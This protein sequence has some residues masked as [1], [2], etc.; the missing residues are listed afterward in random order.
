GGAPKNGVSLFIAMLLPFLGMLLLLVCIKPFA[1]SRLQNLVWGNTG[2]PQLRFISE[3]RFRP[4]LWLT[5]KN[6]LLIVL[7]LG[8]YWPFALVAMT[9]LR[10]EAVSIKT[11]IDPE[12]LV[13][14]A[15]TAQIEA[16]GD[17][18]GDFF[19]LDVGL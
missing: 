15:Q 6:W 13:A 7:T 11:R 5:V 2:T 12:L 10:L 17:A 18:A 4:L 16:A 14:D 9:R 19:G 1:V 3:L 8:L